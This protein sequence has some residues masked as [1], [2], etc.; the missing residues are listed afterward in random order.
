MTLGYCALYKYSYLLTSWLR[1]AI[2]RHAGYREERGAYRDPTQPNPWVSPTHGQLCFGTRFVDARLSNSGHSLSESRRVVP[3]V[4]ATV[5][6]GR[7]GSQVE[8]ASGGG[9]TRDPQ[10]ANSRAGH[11]RRR[12]G[13]AGRQGQGTAEPHHPPGVGEVRSREELQGATDGSQYRPRGPCARPIHTDRPSRLDETVLLRPS[14]WAMWIG[15]EI[16]TI[17]MRY[18][19]PPVRP[20]VPTRAAS[21]PAAP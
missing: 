16:A 13:E 17:I 15:H 3:T 11:R 9:E 2:W 6:G 1:H 12:R 7:E 14:R 20:S 4:A 5:L 18:R 21:R 19:D 8:G 10:A